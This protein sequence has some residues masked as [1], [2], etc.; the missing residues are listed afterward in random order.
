MPEARATDSVDD[1]DDAADVTVDALACEVDNEE[2]EDGMLSASPT[3]RISKLSLVQ[4]LSPLLSP[5][6]PAAALFV[7]LSPL[8]SR[9][10][11]WIIC[12]TSLSDAGDSCGTGLPRFL[13][14]SWF[15]WRRSN[16]ES[17]CENVDNWKYNVC[18]SG[19]CQPLHVGDDLAMFE[20]K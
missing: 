13:G 11:C 9:S 12:S 10:R 20:I 14:A 6:T 5:I 8:A 3:T 4:S 2:D 19:A 18:V 7:L 17:L 16:Q 1:E 15:E